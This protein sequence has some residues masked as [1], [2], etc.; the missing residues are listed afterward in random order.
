MFTQDRSAP[1]AVPAAAP[2]PKAGRAALLK[3][4]TR[5]LHERLD[6]RIMSL[7]PFA[8]RDRYGRFL[9]VQFRFQDAVEAGIDAAALAPFVPDLAERRRLHLIARDIAD[10]GFEAP[11]AEPVARLATPA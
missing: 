4:H 6:A 2:S 5:A 7:G 1:E 11:A 8:D 9:H 10:L 3:E